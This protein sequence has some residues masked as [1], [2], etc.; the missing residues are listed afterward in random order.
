MSDDLDDD[1]WAL[2]DSIGRTA[3]AG[4]RLEPAGD[5]A[6]QLDDELS[7]VLNL[8]E[9]S[10]PAGPAGSAAALSH[11]SD[12]VSSGRCPPVTSVSEPIPDDHKGVSEVILEAERKE[13]QDS[14]RRE[15]EITEHAFRRADDVDVDGSTSMRRAAPL[16]AVADSDR[17][18]KLQSI[19]DAMASLSQRISVIESEGGSDGASADLADGNASKGSVATFSPMQPDDS[20]TRR[21]ALARKRQSIR[22]HYNEIQAASQAEAVVEQSPVQRSAHEPLDESPRTLVRRRVVRRRVARRRVVRRRVVRRYFRILQHRSLQRLAADGQCRGCGWHRPAPSARPAAG[23]QLRRLLHAAHIPRRD[24]S[25]AGASRERMRAHTHSVVGRRAAPRVGA[26]ACALRV[27][28]AVRA[29]A[30]M[31]VHARARIVPA[32]QVR[33]VA[34]CSLRR[35]GCRP[36]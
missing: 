13:A 12:V 3:S 28:A 20:A 11:G 29:L 24:P 33:C 17:S 21:A 19:L 4:F 34:R 5:L 22:T 16:A 18:A 6:A 35:D 31:A 30:C 7:R 27:L 14:V 9:T 32:A 36:R 23:Q 10:A 25:S 8:S 1:D 26:C 15:Q 2:L